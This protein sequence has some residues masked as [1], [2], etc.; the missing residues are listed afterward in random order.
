MHDNLCYVK[1]DRAEAFSDATRPECIPACCPPGRPGP[2]G[3][4][5]SDCLNDVMR[6]AG[7]G[8]VT[9]QAGPLSTGSG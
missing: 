1:L 5:V 9:P 3:T 2:I 6:D 8:D 4:R 7:A